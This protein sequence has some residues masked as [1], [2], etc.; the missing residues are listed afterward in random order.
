MIYVHEEREKRTVYVGPRPGFPEPCADYTNR[1][2]DYLTDRQ[3]PFTVAR[4]NGWFPAYYKG[5]PRIIIPCSNSANVPYFQGRDMTGKSKLRY[6]SPA[7]SRDDSIVVVWPS[8]RAKGTVIVE[9]PMCALAAADLGF[10]GIAVMGNQP[11]VAVLDHISSL[12]RNFQPVIVVP[13]MDM[14]EFG[15]KVLGPLAQDGISGAILVPYAKD[16]AGMSLKERRKL[17][18]V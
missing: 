11:T 17:L 8:E 3:L 9:G 12:V 7:A 6:A 18:W 4:Q 15:P 13:D 16:F 5:A 14:M 2:R 10:L 1:M